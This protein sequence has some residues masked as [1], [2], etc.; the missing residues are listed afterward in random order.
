MKHD[1]SL[2]GDRAAARA[3]AELSAAAGLVAERDRP[4][5]LR[6]PGGGDTHL[7]AL[8]WLVLAA[9]EHSLPLAVVEADLD[10]VPEW[11]RRDVPLLTVLGGEAGQD[12]RRWLVLT[13]GGDGAARASLHAGAHGPSRQAP[14]EE[15]AP[16]L[17]L[18]AGQRLRWV[19]A[20]P[21]QAA[22]LASRAS[23]PG[24]PL[25]P[26]RRLLSL[27]RPD[28]RDL[29]AV[30]VFAVAV[31]VLLL[32][33]PIAVQA[34]VNFVALGGAIPPL[35]VVV[36]LLF[37]GLCAAAVLSAFQ[38]WV[39][40]IL[41][42]R[43]FVRSVA[44]LAA[45][46][47]RVALDGRAEGYGPE[48]VN[49]FFDLETI[50]KRGSFLLLDGL[51][52][53]LSVLV[54][55]VVLAFYHPLL[56]AFDV[57]LLVVIG[58]IVLGPVRR[59]MRTAKAESSAKYEVAAWLEEIARNPLLF[60]SSGVMKSVFERSDR[61]TRAYIE[62]RSEHF[63]V[64]FGQGVAAL[65]LQ[66]LASTALLGIGGLLVIRG[67]LTLGQ[68]VAAELILSLVVSSVAKM[69]KHLEA[70]YD[71][72]AATDKLGRLLDLPLERS[73]GEHHLPTAR[74][75]AAELELRSVTWSPDGGAP[76]FADVSLRVASGERVGIRGPSGAGKSK[77]LELVWGLRTPARGSIRVDGRDLRELSLESLRR[78]AGLVGRIELFEGSVRDNVHLA[79][80]FVS[81]E[82]VREAL[83]RVGL[84]DDVERL[85]DGVHTRLAID[86]QPLSSGQVV[87][88]Q[89]ARAIAGRPLLL[90]VSDFFEGLE[91]HDRDRLLDVLFDRDAPWT[92]VLVTNAAGALERCERVYQL[93]RGRLSEGDVVT[94]GPAATVTGSS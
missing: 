64:A 68:L 21:S 81:D 41:Q 15:L 13:R 22:P 69:G 29:L 65:A 5:R 3:L 34:L 76:L 80:P 61:L 46:L 47:P 6:P 37:L 30:A 50:Q 42:R 49:R 4:L 35:I 83:R 2:E 67:S 84:L 17:G 89:V 26:L 62:R 74:S 51:S 9:E 60:K 52:V 56:L 48:L 88:L 66:V 44:D 73:G 90:L 10:E 25:H 11:L 19:L 86:G 55:L 92:L 8:D 1:A 85:P 16:A 71:L 87:R 94:P 70:F 12:D 33:T 59:G 77:L 53:L 57:L 40:E 39:V 79:R 78:T 63:R 82:D 36:V 72:M 7:D 23:S 24:A 18:V 20:D 14:L 45:R 54:G 28:R 32:A 58:G 75:R 38:T 31:G 43:L 93:A 91:A 27:V